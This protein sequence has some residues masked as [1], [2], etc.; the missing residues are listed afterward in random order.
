[1]TS[2]PGQAGER[3]VIFVGG[4]LLV[5]RGGPIRSKV[6]QQ[7]R[8]EKRL[9]R[10]STAAAELEALLRERAYPQ[11]TCDDR[12]DPSTHV[13][14]QQTNCR[15]VAGYRSIKPRAVELKARPEKGRL[16]TFCGRYLRL[17]NP[18]ERVDSLIRDVGAGCFDPMIPVNELTSQLQVREILHFATNQIWPNFRPL[19]YTA[20]CYQ[21]WVF[22][23]EDKVRL[24]AVLWSAS[25]HQDVLRL[26]YG[27]SRQGSKEQ[28]YLKG[29]ALESLRKAVS[30]Y[31]GTTPIDSI[32]MCILFLAVNDTHGIKLFRDP[33]PFTPTFTG[34]HA[35]DIYGSRDYHA[36]HWKVIQD[37]LGQFGGISVLREFALA[38]L[39]SIS[40]IMNAA[41]TFRKPIYPA[42]GV[43]G[44]MLQL[45]PP[46]VLFAQYGAIS[47]GEVRSKEPGSGFDELL[48][49]SPP[50]RQGLVTVFAHVGQLSHVLQHF[51]KAPCS[52]AALD[53][54]G[55]SRNLVHHRLFSLPDENDD[56][57]QILL[58]S[59]RKPGKDI[60]VSKELYLT[61]RLAVHLY[62]SHVTFPIPQ[63]T[64]VRVPLLQSLYP[65][66]Q[67]LANQ[68]VSG[69]LL[70]W[71]AV[72]SLVASHGTP[73]ADWLLVL[74]KN[75]CGKLKVM[76]LDHL[77]KLLRSFAWVDVAVKH[78]YEGLLGDIFT[79]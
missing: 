20:K 9:Q 61:C 35:L 1:M 42:L 67:F 23:L 62:A 58:V 76:G 30:S 28:F 72:V 34:I 18:N 41:H 22:P 60:K 21:L 56:I 29:L 70:L 45:D 3:Q 52:P 16:C 40:D 24:Y 71:C 64:V 74:V 79:P 17:P 25:Y 31:K 66:L 32:I 43:D 19:G 27:G 78:H 8:R 2:Q 55:D 39:L 15:G 4:P 75:L 48:S 13:H 11:C 54:L 69:P 44:K 33:S 10:Q 46:F 63:T 12:Q 14:A 36:L 59:A 73:I 38:W 53:H 6:L 57:E 47:Q 49:L 7:V 51:S 65:K 68:G 5:D 50:V 37:L 77:L 26:T